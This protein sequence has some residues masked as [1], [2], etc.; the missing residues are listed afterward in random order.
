MHITYFCCF[1]W[2]KGK[3][4]QVSSSSNTYSNQ[5]YCCL[6]LWLLFW[7]NPFDQD[8]SKENLGGIHWS[9]YYNYVFSILG[10]HAIYLGDDKY[11]SFFLLE[12]GNIVTVR[13]GVEL[14]FFLLQC[15]LPILFA[16]YN[17]PPLFIS[18]SMGHVYYGF[19]K[20]LF[21]YLSLFKCI[22]INLY[23]V[24]ILFCMLQSNLQ[25]SWDAEM[26][27]ISS[28]RICDYNGFFKYVIEYPLTWYVNLFMQ[29]A[30]IMGRFQWL[31]CP[32]KVMR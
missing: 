21:S 11:D 2:Y 18:L 6:H 30:N 23:I 20:W 1:P 7:K 10:E 25:C 17:S 24:S 5:W 14:P 31:T 22:E 16:R 19:S 4:L 12:S 15:I 3:W 26:L 9:F 27:C 8:I 28:M 13:L 32:R 29:L